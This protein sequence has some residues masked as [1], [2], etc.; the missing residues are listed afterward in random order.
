MRSTTSSTAAEM[1]IC[2]YVG[3]SPMST[4]HRPISNRLNV[5]M[6]LRPT[7]SPKWPN[8]MPPM[9]RASMPLAN[10]PK[11]ASVPVTGSNCGKKNLLKTSAAAVP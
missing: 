4:V 7:R 5:N 3:S 6:D 1:P 9:G 11:A 2:S 10:A 8:R